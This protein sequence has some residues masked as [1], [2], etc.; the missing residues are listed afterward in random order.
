MTDAQ[1][2]ALKLKI[3]EYLP[4]GKGAINGLAIR[5]ALYQI[6]DDFDL[7]ADTLQAAIDNKRFRLE[8][9][10]AGSW[11]LGEFA[12]SADKRKIF[13]P[14]AD[15]AN[16]QTAPTAENT[17]WKLVLESATDLD[18]SAFTAYTAED[19]VQDAD[20]LVLQQSNGSKRKMSW[21]WLWGKV[22]TAL[23]GKADLVNGKVPVEQLPAFEGGTTV[24]STDDIATE[25]AT[26]KWFTDARVYLAKASSYVIQGTTRAITQN[27]TLGMILGIFENRLNSLATSITSLTNSL[28]N[29]VLRTDTTRTVASTGTIQLIMNRNAVLKVNNATTPGQVTG[30]L[31][32]QLT[33]GEAG[34]VQIL[35]FKAD[36]AYT[37]TLPAG[38]IKQGS[39]T[40]F[41]NTLGAENELWVLCKPDAAGTLKY[42][43]QWI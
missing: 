13:T 1:K 42:Y 38:A 37:I 35:P 7:D 31:A 8:Q 29:Y 16:S 28:V 24:N 34:V 26:N 20:D 22:S 11:K 15:I 25:G 39:K 14:K 41:N 43:Y 17:Y 3:G 9:W 2:T 36:P 30:N 21:S 12:V 5:N 27:D 19:D 18:I 32:I 23:S 4:S 6:V 40:S 10:I 33:G